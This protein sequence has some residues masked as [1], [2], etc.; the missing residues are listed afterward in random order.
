MNW[1]KCWLD[2]RDEQTGDEVLAGS[3]EVAARD[4]GEDWGRRHADAS[5]VHVLGRDVD[6]RVRR[7]VVTRHV[8]YRVAEQAG[9]VA[10]ANP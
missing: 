6:G 10:D 8:V 5:E 4:F 3:L 2:G 9:E 7:F 1:W